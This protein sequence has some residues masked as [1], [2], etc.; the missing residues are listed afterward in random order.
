MMAML[1]AKGLRV[2][3]Y[4]CGP[5]YIDTKF[6]ERICHRPSVNLDA[7][8]AS[9]QHLK[10]V[11]RHYAAD[12]DACVVEGMMGLFDGYERDRGSCAEVARI[13]GLP[14]IMVVDARSAAYSMAPLLAGFMHFREGVD[15][16]GVIFNKVGSQRHAA[17]LQEVSDDLGLPCLGFLPRADRLETGNRYLGLDFSEMADEEGWAELFGKHFNWERIDAFS[18]NLPCE[19]PSERVKKISGKTLVARNAEAFAFI[20]Q[21]TL[22]QFEKV[23]FFDPE[24][25]LPIPDD[26]SLLYLPGGYPEKHMKALAEAETTRTS[27]ADYARRGGKIVAECGGMMY[28]CHSIVGDDGEYPMCD[29]LPARVTAR[30]NDRKLSL[31]YRKFMMNGR[32]YRGHEFHYTQLLPHDLPSVAQVWNARGQAVATPVFKWK[33][34][35]ASYTHLYWG[36]GDIQQLFS[37]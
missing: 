29:V 4:K 6:H 34:V 35:V 8:M 5:D 19:Q 14:V 1:V 17:M 36:N 28:L 37:E 30:R 9:E 27:I 15:I 23:E 13:L 11:Y 24:A 20:Y 22:D 26:I 3:P 18:A 32:E 7:F 25:N 31:G 12:A 33:N 16:A 2:Q 21:E 10:D